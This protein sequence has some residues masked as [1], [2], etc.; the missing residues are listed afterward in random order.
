MFYIAVGVLLYILVEVY[1]G[2]FKFSHP[3]TD[4]VGQMNQIWEQIFWLIF[5]LSHYKNQVI[6]ALKTFNH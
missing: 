5:N 6:L 2:Q 4:N 3:H 1:L